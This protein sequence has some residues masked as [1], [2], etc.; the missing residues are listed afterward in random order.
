[1]VIKQLAKQLTF[2][3]IFYSIPLCPMCFLFKN[4]SFKEKINKSVGEK[5][6]IRSRPLTDL[7]NSSDILRTEIMSVIGW[8]LSRYLLLCISN[9]MTVIGN[10]S[11]LLRVLLIGSH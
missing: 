8:S 3:F 5:K 10:H 7:D 6:I 11:V 2:V 1:M 4:Y 9:K